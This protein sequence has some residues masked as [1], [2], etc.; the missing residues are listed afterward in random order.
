[1]EI[2]F[3]KFGQTW[4]EHGFV[5]QNAGCEYSFLTRVKRDM[6]IFLEKKKGGCLSFVFHGC[7]DHSISSYLPIIDSRFF[8]HKFIDTKTTLQKIYIQISSECWTTTTKRALH[9]STYILQ[10]QQAPKIRDCLC[11]SPQSVAI[12]KLERPLL[13]THDRNPA[14]SVQRLLQ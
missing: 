10:H 12:D 3:W 14:T 1:M 9:L 11:K 13:K 8:G 5:T 7:I 2:S 6:A 4:V